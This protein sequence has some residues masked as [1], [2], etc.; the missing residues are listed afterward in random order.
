M[1]MVRPTLD[2][3]L[4]KLE[5]EFVHGYREGSCVFYVSLTNESS[6]ERFVSE[7]DKRAWG[8][9]WDQQSEAFNLF[10]ESDLE[11]AHLKN[12][13]FYVCDGNHRL[14]S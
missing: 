13:M 7:E 10:V 3:D 4:K 5:Q 8:P 6:E 14:L 11:L 1:P 2:S 9:L 12:R